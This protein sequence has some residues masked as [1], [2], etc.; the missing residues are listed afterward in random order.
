MIEIHERYYNPPAINP[1]YVRSSINEGLI[2]PEISSCLTITLV[3]T[4]AQDVLVG[5][6][7]GIG[8]PAG[9]VTAADIAQMQ[10][11]VALCRTA[12]GVGGVA[13]RQALLIGERDTWSVN[14]P[15]AYGLI[16]AWLPT[17][18]CTRGWVP[19]SDIRDITEGGNSHDVLINR[20]SGW[21]FFR[22]T[23]L[24]RNRQ[25]GNSHRWKWY[26]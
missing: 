26:R 2:Y 18:G 23:A 19:G 17:L 13:P 22:R 10:A 3:W 8:N 9:L 15:A 1:N 16:T 5:A 14:V 7:L 4:G 21:S 20:P 24:V 25:T 12:A 6:H 11:D